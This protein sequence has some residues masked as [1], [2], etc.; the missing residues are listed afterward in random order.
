MVCFPGF[1][2]VIGFNFAKKNKTEN[3]LA[4]SSGE[5]ANLAFHPSGSPMKYAID[6]HQHI[7]NNEYGSL[8]FIGS[9]DI[10]KTLFLVKLASQHGSV[11]FG[12]FQ[13]KLKLEK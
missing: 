1:L 11:T 9:V 4:P 3:A 12:S 7:H 10:L 13:H 5:A 6:S 8:I 2:T